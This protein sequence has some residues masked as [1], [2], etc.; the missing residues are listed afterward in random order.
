MRNATHCWSCGADVT[1]GGTCSAGCDPFAFR[2][3]GPFAPLPAIAPQIVSGWRCPSCGAG[4]APWQS[5][6]ACT[7]IPQARAINATDTLSEQGRSVEP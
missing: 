4:N 6:C 2:V 1:T 5:R 7:P 3:G